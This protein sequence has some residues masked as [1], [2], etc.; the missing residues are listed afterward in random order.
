MAVELFNRFF[1]VGAK[2]EIVTNTQAPVLIVDSSDGQGLR[3]SWETS[4]T[5]GSNSN[6]GSFVIYNLSKTLIEYIETLQSLIGN[7]GFSA[8]LSFGWEGQVYELL[9]GQI[10]KLLTQERTA[11]DVLTM[12]EFS[13]NYLNNQQALPEAIQAA[14]AFWIGGFTSI[15]TSLGVTLSA[16]F[17]TALAANPIAVSVPTFSAVFANDPQADMDVLVSAMGP[18]YDW[19]I[20]SG[21]IFLLNQGLYSDQSPPAVLQPS[22]GLLT[23]TPQD[24]GGLAITA[25]GNPGISPGQQLLVNDGLGKPLGGGPLRIESASWSGDTDSG[26]VMNIS[27]RQPNIFV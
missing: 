14:D 9:T 23:F 12:V 21:E 6:N 11:N 22:S 10:S 5:F 7:T 3:I 25:V 17:L 27:A 4:K 24:D 20:I 8:T 13:E 18:G 19:V 2:V 1:N 16:Q 26:C 15:A